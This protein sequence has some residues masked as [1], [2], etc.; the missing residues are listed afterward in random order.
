M[1]CYSPTA[2]GVSPANT[3]GWIGSAMRMRYCLKCFATTLYK[4]RITG[5]EHG[6]QLT[7]G[8]PAIQTEAHLP[9]AGPADASAPSTRN[10]I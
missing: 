7:S 8:S 9:A 3:A 6:D 2:V 1:T 10:L 5:P 4:W